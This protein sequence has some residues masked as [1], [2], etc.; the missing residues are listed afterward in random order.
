MAVVKTWV[1]HIESICIEATTNGTTAVDLFT[2]EPG[3]LV[4]GVIARVK[5]A[6]TRSAGALNFMVGD[7]D[8]ADGFLVAKDAKTAGVISGTDPDDLGDYMKA[9][10]AC[11]ATSANAKTRAMGK[12]YTT[13]KTLKLVLD[14]VADSEATIQV[15]VQYAKAP[16]V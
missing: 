7:N 13:S 10:V 16:T 12:W 6:G 11:S 2:L 9:T 1:S 5:V 3:S 4:L 8:D 15:M 14:Q